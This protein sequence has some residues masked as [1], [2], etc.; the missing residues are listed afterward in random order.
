MSLT[1]TVLQVSIF[2]AGE[3][4]AAQAFVERHI[5]VGRDPLMADLVIASGQMSREHAL[6]E[7]DG[8]RIFVHDLGSTNGVL[9]NGQKTERAQIQPGDAVQLG[10][11]MLHLALGTLG[12]PVAAEAPTV[13]SVASVAAAL[14][15]V[16]DFFTTDNPFAVPA[17]ETSDL[18]AWARQFDRQLDRPL[19]RR[20]LRPDEAARLLATLGASDAS[21]ASGAVLDATACELAEGADAGDDILSPGWSLGAALTAPAAAAA[22]DGAVPLSL[23]IVT[24]RGPALARVTWLDHGAAFKTQPA[25]L[26]RRWRHPRG[27]A[28]FV[29]RRNRAGGCEVEVADNSAWTLQRGEALLDLAVGV[30]EGWAR[31]RRG[32]VFVTLAAAD[33]LVCDQPPLTHHVR[34]VTRAAGREAPPP[35]RPVRPWRPWLGH[36]T[37][38]LAVQLVVLVVLGWRGRET[39]HVDAGATTAALTP[40]FYVSYDDRGAAPSA[41]WGNA[42]PGLEGVVSPPPVRYFPRVPGGSQGFHVF[43]LKRV[44]PANDPAR[45]APGEGIRLSRAAAFL[46][47]DGPGIGQLLPPAGSGNTWQLQDEPGN[48]V[49]V[50]AAGHLEPDAVRAVIH[51]NRAGLEACYQKELPPDAGLTGRFVLT[52]GIATSGQVKS[53]RKNSNLATP[54]FDCLSS[55]LKRMRFGRFKG[56]ELSATYAFV[57]RRGGFL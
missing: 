53:V 52:F 9:I 14:D 29:V 32:R 55:K 20:T 13:A 28:P 57:L 18:T 33:T 2:R 48:V 11:H 42:T 44:G 54:L 7:H 25:R 17:P 3:L 56:A 27:G 45:P 39:W 26:G 43:G 6:L 50:S 30:R 16:E 36:A 47:G 1:D 22:A 12:A 38:A 8:Q 19:D 34:F 24:L 4:V 15:V 37:F 35:V 51:A 31:R 5:V 40:A 41:P 49:T 10:E 23:Q 21:D 46:R